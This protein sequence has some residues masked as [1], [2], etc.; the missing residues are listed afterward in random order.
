MKRTYLSW[1][2]EELKF[3][4]EN[5]YDKPQDFLVQ[6]LRQRKWSAVLKKANNLEIKRIT[7]AMKRKSDVSILLHDNPISY[8]WL[9]F[10]MADGSFTDRRIQLGV[11]GKDLDHLKKF[12]RFVNSTNKIYKLKN[13]DHYRVK[14]TSVK[15]V[16]SLKQK[17]GI[18]NRKTYVPC[19]L[20][21]IKDSELLFSLIVGFI[22]GDGSV[23]QNKQFPNSYSLDIVSH[24][25]WINNF[26]FIKAF[27]YNYFDEIDNSKPVK[28]IPHKTHLPQDLQVKKLYEIICIKLNKKTLLTKIKNK[29]EELNLPFM[30]RKLGI[31]Q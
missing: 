28:A 11:A 13:E 31:I 23:T 12:L 29:A 24:P 22:D 5:F 8:Y 16:I 25:N 4:K 17:F 18:S 20:Q 19:N 9:G 2:D 1:T 3:L 21:K 7:Q 26:N 6:N 14:L 15:E 10:L 30:K 27:I